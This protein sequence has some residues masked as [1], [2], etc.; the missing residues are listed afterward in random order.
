MTVRRAS[1]VTTAL[2]ALVAL[3][4]GAGPAGAGLACP[5]FDPN[6]SADGAVAFFGQG[7]DGFGTLNTTGLDQTLFFAMSPGEHI[8]TFALIQNTDDITRDI[9][10]KGGTSRDRSSFSVKVTLLGSGRDITDKI[11]GATGKRFRDRASL[12]YA[13]QIRIRVKK[14]DSAPFDD[15]LT[16]RLRSSFDQ[17]S[18]CGDTVKL[19]AELPN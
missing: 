9:V 16:V 6:A 8:A 19:K 10:V 2:A 17:A 14:L 15:K 7:W 5:P 11:F 1:V 3:G 13:G 12:A 4:F 18:K